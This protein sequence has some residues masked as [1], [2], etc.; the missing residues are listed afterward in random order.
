LFH[1]ALKKLTQIHL[2]WNGRLKNKMIAERNGRDKIA[3]R[4]SGWKGKGLIQSVG[5]Q[6]KQQ[7]KTGPDDPVD[8]CL[9]SG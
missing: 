4:Q 5:F 1:N 3:C 2:F 6:P 7:K 8:D 9:F